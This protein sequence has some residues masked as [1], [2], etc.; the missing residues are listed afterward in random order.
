MGCGSVPNLSFSPLVLM[1]TFPRIDYSVLLVWPQILGTGAI[2]VF[3]NWVATTYLTYGIF[4]I[5][6]LWTTFGIWFYLITPH[7]KKKKQFEI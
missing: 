2:G 7:D 6:L 4:S 3:F 5:G 1:K